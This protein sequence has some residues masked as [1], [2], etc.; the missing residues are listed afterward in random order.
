MNNTGIIPLTNGGSTV[1]DCDL[2]PELTKK[3]WS[4]SPEGYAC[5]IVGLGSRNHHKK[6][7]L[8][9]VINKTPE[10]SETDHI[11][12][13]KL[14]NRRENL[15]T[16]T[17]SENQR[18]ARK[19]KRLGRST[20]EFKGVYWS[21]RRNKWVAQIRYG[22]KTR[23]LGGFDLERDAAIAYNGAASLLFGDFALL[24]KV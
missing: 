15:R 22:G 3:N 12:G 9:R 1:V 17:R 20:S 8:H 14:D 6:I 24:N 7:Y 16:A 2:L 13:D 18:H 19:K 5:S 11:N 21:R 23:S 4:R 10:G